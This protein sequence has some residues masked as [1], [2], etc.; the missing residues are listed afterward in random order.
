MQNTLN[1][2]QRGFILIV[3]IYQK[4]FSPDHSSWGKAMFPGGYCKFT[5]SC[6]SYMICAI[7]KHGAIKGA[8]KGVWRVLRCNPFSH[9]GCDLP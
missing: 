6:S 7:E 4:T 5:P 2:L 3:K 1:I 9:G 8:L